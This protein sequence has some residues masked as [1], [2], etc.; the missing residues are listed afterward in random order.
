[1]RLKKYLNEEFIGVYKYGG[2]HTEIYENPNANEIRFMPSIQKTEEFLNPEDSIR[3]IAYAPSEQLFMWASDGGVHEFVLDYLHSKR[4]IR[5]AWSLE[6]NGVFAGYAA[7]SGS[8]MEFTRGYSIHGDFDW[9]WLS[10][11]FSNMNRVI[12]Y[13]RANTEPT[14][15]ARK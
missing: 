1:M 10:K 7:R 3:F 13:I 2:W 5:A 15:T 4:K 9:E 12:S 6:A 14:R 8:K 11:Y